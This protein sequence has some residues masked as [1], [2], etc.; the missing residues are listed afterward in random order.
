MYRVSQKYSDLE[1]SRQA[2]RY[3]YAGRHAARQAGKQAGRH[4][5]MHTCMHPRM[6]A[7]L[8]YYASKLIVCSI[9][10]VICAQCCLFTSPVRLLGCS[11]V[12]LSATL[13]FQIL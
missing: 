4:A 13:L 11:Y 10:D 9:I 1:D 7:Q 3:R 12:A 2:G 6:H 5:D 8:Q